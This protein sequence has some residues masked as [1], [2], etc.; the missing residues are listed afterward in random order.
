MATL[1]DTAQIIFEKAR[2]NYPAI[3]LYG[4]EDMRNQKEVKD[5][6][7][8]L[9]ASAKN[10][11]DKRALYVWTYGKGLVKES[12]GTPA[13]VE[14]TELPPGLFEALPKIKERAIIILRDLDEFFS[15]PVVYSGI[16]DL[17]PDFK[18][19]CR[20]LVVSSAV[21]NMPPRLEKEFTLVEAKLPDKDRIHGILDGILV[22]SSLDKGLEPS[23]A[24]KK[25]LVEAALGMT[26]NAAE[27]ALSL[28]FIRPRIHNNAKD[29][30]VPQM[31]LW[32]PAIVM[33]EKCQELKKTGLLEYIPVAPD[34]LNQ[35]GGLGLLKD[36]VRKRKNA[37]TEEARKFGLPSPKGILMVGPP[38]S[39]KSLSGKAI[40]GELM[41]PLLKFDMGKVFGSL[42]GQSEAN[43][44][45]AISVA[46]AISPCILW[47]DEI[48]KG[49][50]GSNAGSLDS[51]VGA[52][53]LGSL[54][55][56][57]QE[58]TSPVF[59]YAT[60]NDVTGLPPELLRKGRFDEMFSV[61]LPSD[62]E[63]AE[64][65]EIH[66]RKRNRQGLL[67][68]GIIQIDDIVSRTEGY[69]GAEIESC[70]VEGMFNAF[71]NGKDLNMLDLT[72]A[73][74][75]TVPL[76]E[77]MK[78]RLDRLADWCRKRTRPA[79]G[80]EPKKANPFSGRMVEH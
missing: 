12:P 22:G 62:D 65:F 53:V 51:G 17:M 36:W 15:E 76:S 9:N 80:I 13:K 39:G 1:S 72:D 33:A 58:K 54:L 31:E 75:S 50:A 14:D 41:L 3:Y 24:R 23:D 27:N 63:R 16:K 47:I 46:E 37:F 32:D 52:R 35:V 56:W 30:D 29:K 79:N 20:M 25:E 67:E 2:A 5:A 7:D 71:A 28:S 57:M 59:V 26:A 19:N 66:L 18:M 34:G 21:L 10:A 73:F 60:C 68:K 43:I 6:L 78:E 74:D 4:P 55:T 38:G 11:K 70:I 8:A 69:S 61:S 49:L 45:T 64:I 40:S 42:V 44:R 77:T 48:E